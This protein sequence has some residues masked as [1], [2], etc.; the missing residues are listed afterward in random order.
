MHLKEPFAYVSP[1]L[2]K[3]LIPVSGTKLFYEVLLV[4]LFTCWLVFL[5]FI[6]YK[7]TVYVVYTFSAYLPLLAS[8]SSSDIT[9]D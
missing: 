9:D 2:F 8:D 3:R 1:A 4:T 6:L 5:N 7:D